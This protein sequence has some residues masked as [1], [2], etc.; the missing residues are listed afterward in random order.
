M[1]GPTVLA[2][3]KSTGGVALYNRLLLQELLAEGY[4]SHTVCLSDEGPEYAQSL[5]DKGLSAE[6][7]AMARYSIDPSGDL[8][9]LRQITRI[10]RDRQPDVII[11]HGS[12]AGFLGRIIGRRTGTPVIYCQASMP[13]LRRVQ[14]WKAP[15]YWSL[16]YVVSKIGGHIVTLTERALDT[17]VKFHLS[18]TDRISVIR[19]GV[20]IARFSPAPDRAEAVAAIGLD[21]SRLVVGWMGR[22]EPQKAPLDY[23]A[24]LRIVAPQHPNVQFVVAGGGRM[25]AEV[26][27]A[28]KDAGLSANVSFLGW[29][30][31]PVKTLRAFDVFTLSSHWEGLPL[32]LLEAMATGCCPVST[33]VDGCVDAVV[34]GQTGRLVPAGD[35]AAF[36]DALDQVLTDDALRAAFADASRQRAVTL[37]D[38]RTM[39]REWKNLIDR[40][41][42]RS[43]AYDTTAPVKNAR[44][45]RT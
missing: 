15:I 3:T 16:D 25:Q 9:V 34:D 19:T 26:A 44:E 21:P 28:I 12:K 1:T 42:R 23:V 2:I 43:S 32:T 45:G 38:K 14:G 5:R 7:L 10:T 41:S 31:D 33:D 20:D 37:F 8:R 40:L 13:F 18:R 11:C 22:M 35:P 36:A 29:Q 39:V 30:D 17:T 4:S 6:P 24:A 27:A